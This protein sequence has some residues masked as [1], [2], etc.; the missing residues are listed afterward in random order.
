METKHKQYLISEHLFRV[1]IRSQY[2]GIDIRNE[3]CDEIGTGFAEY[4]DGLNL[5]DKQRENIL[6]KNE[7]DVIMNFQN[8]LRMSGFP[9]AYV[10]HFTQF[11]DQEHEA[12]KY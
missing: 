10:L 4:L 1:F 3:T 11:V 7:A 8:P 2:K 6:P 9:A 12:N 5:T